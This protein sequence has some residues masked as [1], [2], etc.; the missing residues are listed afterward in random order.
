MAVNPGMAIEMVLIMPVSHGT[1]CHVLTSTSSWAMY[2]YQSVRRSL[3]KLFSPELFT[4]VKSKPLCHGMILFDGSRCKVR[5]KYTSTQR[6]SRH[7]EGRSDSG[8]LPFKGYGHWDDTAKASV[9]HKVALSFACPDGGDTCS[10][11]RTSSVTRQG[12]IG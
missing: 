8:Q 11:S 9:G 10:L 3:M 2:W 1:A 4:G 12:A 6:G 7:R 5:S